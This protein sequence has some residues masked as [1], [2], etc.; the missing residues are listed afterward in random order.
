MK[1]ATF[2]NVLPYILCYIAQVSENKNDS[3]NKT[4][5]RLYN[6]VPDKSKTWKENNKW[7]MLAI[8][9]IVLLFK[10][11]THVP[12]EH[13]F[14]LVSYVIGIKS[15]MNFLTPNDNAEYINASIMCILLTL[16]YHD[17]IPKDKKNF[18]YIY[19]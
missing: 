16:I 1:Q 19:I 2:A 8:P 5:D 6:Y 14:V 7:I 15:L 12:V 9:L 11:Q 3:P 18:A 4:K 10:S 13:A 17:I